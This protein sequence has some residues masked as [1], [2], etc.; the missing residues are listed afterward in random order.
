MN[1][2][3]PALG[4][5][6][7]RTVELD[8]VELLAFHGCGYLGLAHD[9]QVREDAVAAL[10]RNGSSGLASRRTSGNLEIH[11]RLESRLSEFMGTEAALV[12]EGGYIA[13]LAALQGL[14]ARG[15]E[16]A[17]LDAD[18][19]PSLVDGAKLGEFE[20]FD[21][22][23]GDVNRAVAL[24]DR[25]AHRS[26]LILTDGVFG[27]HGRL[28]PIPELLRHLPESG[29]LLVDDSHG[30]GVLGGRGRGSIEVFAAPLDRV[31]IT[32]SLSKALGSS[33]AFIAGSADVIESIR[34]GAEA[35]TATSALAPPAA[36]AALAALSLLESEPERLERLRANTGQ[37]HR[38]ARRIGLGSTGTFL[39]ILRI[40]FPD[41]IDARR[42]SSAL[43]VD[44]IFAP[45]L[46]Y[47]GSESGGTVRIAVTSEHTAHDLRRLEE[48]LIRHLPGSM[49]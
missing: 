36:A 34:R 17:L 27:M 43:H 9:P 37:L 41:E 24:M 38:T 48:A 2:E 35:F 30:V 8:G 5:T 33:G 20:R 14:G 16:V 32:S 31:V 25:H 26:P 39:P 4:A 28:A 40:Q 45:A 12:L 44:G 49:E 19:H 22:G 3:R 42:L 23:A 46:C 10:S 29:L 11:E 18:A 15:H 6:T 7:A 13:D 21:Y 47:P 1:R